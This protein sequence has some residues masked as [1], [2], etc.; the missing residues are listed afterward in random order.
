MPRGRAP[1]KL[2]EAMD[3]IKD[4]GVTAADLEQM[5]YGHDLAYRAQ[6]YAKTAGMVSP[7]L[8]KRTTA[9]SKKPAVTTSIIPSDGIEG[10]KDNTQFV[11]KEG[12]LTQTTDRPAFAQSMAFNPRVMR[13]PVP[14]YLE[15]GIMAA[16]H[17]WNWPIDIRPDDFIDTVIKMFFRFVGVEL[18]G[19]GAY[20]EP[21]D[22]RELL[23]TYEL[24]ERTGEIKSVPSPMTDKGEENAVQER[25]TFAETNNEGGQ[26]DGNPN[27][28][29]GT[30]IGDKREDSGQP[31]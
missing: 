4:K 1:D 29:T 22:L 16:H 8:I 14:V 11:T 23:A 25:P 18:A 27:D 9:A 17:K 7:I 6:R 20:Y 10:D 28:E 13:L 26:P 21:N 3:L 30:D 2:M 12:T 15:S 31:L 24:N 5:G 19:P